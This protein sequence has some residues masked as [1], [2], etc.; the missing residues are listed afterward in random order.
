MKI[1]ISSKNT[2][3][4]ELVKGRKMSSISLMKVVGVFVNPN[5]M[6]NHLKRSS[7]D[8]KAVFY[9]SEGSICTW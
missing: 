4:Y 2:T 3:V 1:K 9:R 6:T 8:L 5:G 7:L